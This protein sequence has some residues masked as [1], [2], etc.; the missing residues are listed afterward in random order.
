MID[1]RF[2]AA[3]F[4]VLAGVIILN[5]R[6][7]DKASRLISEQDREKIVQIFNSMRKSMLI[8]LVSIFIIYFIAQ[9]AL[10]KH[11][12]LINTLVICVFLAIAAIS[13]FFAILKIRKIGLPKDYIRYFILSRIAVFAGMI[14]FA[15]ILFIH[16]QIM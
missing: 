2:L 6:L 3:A 4:M 9:G 8:P 13:Y 16:Q 1:F 5:R 12:Q 15:F 10:K 11:I 14:I 7:N